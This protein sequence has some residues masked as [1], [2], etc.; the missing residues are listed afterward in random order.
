MDM[1]TDADNGSGVSVLKDEDVPEI[2]F[3][4]TGWQA[5][6][7]TTHFTTVPTARR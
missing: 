6:P 4:T 5:P 1:E 2:C 7:L 3:T